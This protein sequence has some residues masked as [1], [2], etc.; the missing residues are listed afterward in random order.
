MDPL[1]SPTLS[2]VTVDLGL[3]TRLTLLAAGLVFLLALGLGVWKYRQM[4][5]SAD[6]LA[7][8]YV[9][10]AHR[11]ALLYSFAI[12]LIA[13]FV[14]LSSWPTW[15]NLAA[16]G[17]LVFFFV[18]AIASYIV[19]GALRD[20]TNQF[21]HPSPMTHGGM[22][23]LIVGELGGFAVLLAGFVDGQFLS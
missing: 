18:V 15:V 20:T 22:V 16:A 1:S 17:V 11:A 4:A 8:P 7:H 2:A 10:I 19:H 3:D 13:A 21:E 6:H 5:T 14:E 12:L 9:D 23:A